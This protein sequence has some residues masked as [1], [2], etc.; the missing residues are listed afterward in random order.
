MRSSVII[1]NHN[2]EKFLASTLASLS[3]SSKPADE[4]LIVDDKVRPS[5]LLLDTISK[6]KLLNIRLL[7]L[8]NSGQLEKI[9]FAFNTSEGQVIF[10]LDADDEFTPYHIECTLNL[11]SEK[12]SPDCVISN[13]TT[14]DIDSNKCSSEY[15]SSFSNGRPLPET[16]PVTSGLFALRSEPTSCLALKRSTL[17]NIFPADHLHED[18]IIAAD[19]YIH[20]AIRLRSSSILYSRNPSVLYRIHS[21]NYSLGDHYNSLINQQRMAASFEKTRNSINKVLTHDAYVLMSLILLERPIT[22]K[23]FYYQIMSI[24]K[25]S[26]NTPLFWFTIIQ[27][28]IRIPRNLFNVLRLSM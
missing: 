22:L 11:F 9:D 28:I 2:Y 5:K 7:T 10:L 20:T 12:P 27:Y 26:N 16:M 3:A 15:S 24:L 17:E 18:W 8:P 1:T 13:F 14:V 23:D 21:S 4:I 19:A 25:Y 6:F